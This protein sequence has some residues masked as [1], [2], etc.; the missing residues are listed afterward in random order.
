MEVDADA[1]LLSEVDV[2]EDVDLLSVEDVVEEAAHNT[3][4]KKADSKGSAFFVMLRERKCHP[5][6]P[7]PPKGKTSASYFSL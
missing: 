7:A 1:V 6:T 3:A 5:S 4:Y 2:V